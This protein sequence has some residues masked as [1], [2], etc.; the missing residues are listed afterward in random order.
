[1]RVQHSAG[2]AV[3][4]LRRYRRGAGGCHGAHTRG[5]QAHR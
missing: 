3:G 4:A 5:E 1:M 2:F